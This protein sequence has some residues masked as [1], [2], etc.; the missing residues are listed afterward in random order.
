M[1]VKEISAVAL[2]KYNTFD[3]DSFVLTA[4]TAAADGF[5]VDLG[6]YA[7]HKTLLLFKNTN[8]GTTA[9]K[10]T[11]K[12][13]NGLQGTT[14][15]EAEIDAGNTAMVVIESGRFLNVSGTK[16]GKVAIIPAHAE[17]TMAAVVL[18]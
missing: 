3:L 18:P 5:L 13:G 16:K 6:K 12:A 17:V 9:Y 15:I 2:A 14:D 4:S 1:A 8:A 7:D 10:V 11:I